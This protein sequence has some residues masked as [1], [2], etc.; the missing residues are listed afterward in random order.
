MALEGFLPP[1]CQ[2]IPC[3]VTPRDE[4][5][6]VCDFHA[7][8]YPDAEAE[9]S[10]L[11][12]VLGVMEYVS[13]ARALLTHLRQWRRPVVLSYCTTE[14]IQDREQRR[15][16]GWVNDYSHN[17]LVSLLREVGFAVQRSDRIDKVQW[18]FVFNLLLRRR[19][20]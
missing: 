18:L 7:G 5:T 14:G 1:D 8:E 6:I 17:E 16:L 10:D 9:R 20:V 4:R 15:G 11:I 19:R 13:D 2:Y 12:S 3:D